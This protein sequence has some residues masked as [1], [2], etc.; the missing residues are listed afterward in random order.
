[1]PVDAQ[2]KEIQRT[3]KRLDEIINALNNGKGI[4][5]LKKVAELMKKGKEDDEIEQEY[6]K[7]RFGDMIDSAKN[8]FSMIVG[9]V[10]DA[11]KNFKGYMKDLK[12]SNTLIGKTFKFG[13]AL[14]VET[15]KRIR[16]IF[17][18]VIGH[19]AEVLG[20]VYDLFVTIKDGIVSAFTF[21]KS[22]T[23]DIF[24]GKTPKH[25]TVANKHLKKI[26]DN[27]K[28]KKPAEA[29]VSGMG[30]KKAED[31]WT[32]LALLAAGVAMAIGGYYKKIILPFQMLWKALTSIP[33]IGKLISGAGGKIFGP[34]MEWVGKI[35]TWFE[36]IP[37][38]GKFIGKFFKYFK[39]GMEYLG[40]PLQ[41]V[42]SVIDF[43]KG[44]MNTEGDLLDKIMGGL[45]NVVLEFLDLPI[46]A[47]G[48]II[49]KVAG[50]FGI[51]IT[52]AAGTIKKWISDGFDILTGWIRTAIDMWPAL[53]AE[54]VQ[55][56]WDTAVTM[57]KLKFLEFIDRIQVI[58]EDIV[59]ILDPVIQGIKNAFTWLSEL[60]SPAFDFIANIIT[61]I[62]EWYES[63][64]TG[65][66][67]KALSWLGFNVASS[68]D[69]EPVPTPTTSPGQSETAA[70]EVNKKRLEALRQ[71]EERETQRSND[72]KA[73]AEAAE[74]AA[75]AAG[76][77]AANV[78]VN[79]SSSQSNRGGGG[80][81]KQPTDE[82]DSALT[83]A[84]LSMEFSF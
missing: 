32:L 47:L 24:F 39:L 10:K 69:K 16:S 12:N 19:V 81:S 56:R 27:T 17:D 72:L 40:W 26:A 29:A 5:D 51:E 13:A 37:F 63:F 70:D 49:E 15:S 7:S 73:A 77:A 54:Y 34:V 60:L 68:K 48:W 83:L 55:P 67:M 74:A 38:F 18:K 52:D 8:A 35:I 84:N 4:E 36:K 23:W 64:K 31:P 46:E 33:F 6:I 44:F 22:L 50:F 25:A 43:I 80:D 3:N 42:M 57:A 1:M 11:G 66:I 2:L 62:S 58:W 30:P 65:T 75:K 21:V 14:W 59:G 20:P 9:G 76:T 53:W 61:K 28:P 82:V 41:I 45:K 78:S 71:T 79:Q